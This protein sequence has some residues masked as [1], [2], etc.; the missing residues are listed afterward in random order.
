MLDV[1]NIY[2]PS[3]TLLRLGTPPPPSPIGLPSPT[4]ETVVDALVFLELQS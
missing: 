3:H 1:E 2:N 4:A